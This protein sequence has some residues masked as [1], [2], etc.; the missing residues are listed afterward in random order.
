[1]KLQ[2]LLVERHRPFLMLVFDVQVALL[3][4]N[5]PRA[6][7]VMGRLR[8]ALE[9]HAAVEESLLIPAFVQRVPHPERGAAPE[10]FEAEHKRILHLMEEV[11]TLL[12]G[13]FPMSDRDAI[14][15]LEKIHPLKNLI[16]HHELREETLLA[17][18]L[19]AGMGEEFEGWLEHVSQAFDA[20][21]GDTNCHPSPSVDTVSS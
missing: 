2:Q 4:R 3:D 1:M 14:T 13:E 10:L 11:L 8:R 12:R 18:A 16:Q 7:Q 19:E 17:P 9:Q 15:L 6:F 21:A 20:V 5:R